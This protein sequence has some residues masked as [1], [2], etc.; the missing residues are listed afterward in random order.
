MSFPGLIW[1][2]EEQETLLIQGKPTR[3]NTTLLGVK[4]QATL[5][6]GRKLR[7]QVGPSV[8]KLQ[9][10][11]GPTPPRWLLCRFIMEGSKGLAVSCALEVGTSTSP[12]IL[13]QSIVHAVMSIGGGKG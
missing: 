2:K 11:K 5:N 10:G 6:L 7:R 4:G 12:T 1:E 3:N 13:P 8:E 9:R